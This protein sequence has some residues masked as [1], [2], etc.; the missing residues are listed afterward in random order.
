[1]FPFQMFRQVF[2]FL[3]VL[4]APALAGMDGRDLSDLQAFYSFDGGNQTGQAGAPVPDDS[5]AGNSGTLYGA[6]YVPEGGGFSL[7]FDGRGAFAKCAHLKRMLFGGDPFSVD[8][9]IKLESLKPGV[10]LGKKGEGLDSAGWL[11]EVSESG[12]HL[13]VILADGSRHEVLEFPLPSPEEWHHVALVRDGE[14][15]AAYVDGEEVE[16]R[17]DPAMGMDVSNDGAFLHLGKTFGSIRSFHGRLDD[18]AVW[19]RA[20]T[21]EEIKRAVE[22]LQSEKKEQAGAPDKGD[23]R[24]GLVFHYRFDEDP[25]KVASDLS[26]NGHNGTIHDGQYLPAENDEPGALRFNG[27][28]TYVDIPAA[29]GLKI[30]GDMTLEMWVRENGP[31]QT[32]GSLLFGEVSPGA[33]YLFSIDSAYNLLFSLR[34]ESEYGY[35]RVSLPVTRRF[36]DSEWAHLAVVVEYP[37]CRFYRNGELVRDQF[38]PI[39][40]VKSQ[41]GRGVRL[42]GEP[43]NNYFSPIDLREFSLHRR[44]LTP[45][46]IAARAKGEE[47]AGLS[48]AELA[49]EPDWYS[50]HLKLRYTA[51]DVEKAGA[52]TQF[53]LLVDGKVV[54]SKEAGL[55][56]VSGSRSG[57]S[58]AEVSFP[59][60]DYAGKVV[61][62]RARGHEQLV[63]TTAALE[64]PAWIQ[65]RIGEYDGV[66]KP[67]TPI[68]VSRLSDRNVEV[69]VWGR[70]YVFDGSLFPSQ[71]FA[72]NEGLLAGSSHLLA[73]VG[74]RKTD[75]SPGPI[76]V[77]KASADVVKLSQ[78]WTG[79]NLKLLVEATL[80]YDGFLRYRCVLGST[81]PV[82]IQQLTLTLPLRA[83]RALFCYADRAYPLVEGNYVGTFQSGAIQKPLG[84]QFS[85]SVWIGDDD[86]GLTWQAESD[87]HW[88]PADP[89]KTLEVLPEGK[90]VRFKANFL[91]TS[92]TLRPG[93]DKVYEF[94]LL[95]TP[96]KPLARDAWDLRIARYEPWGTDFGL[97]DRKVNGRP[98]LEVIHESGVRRLF[99]FVTDAYSWPMPVHEKFSDGLSRMVKAVHDGNL[100]VHP[101][102]IHQR[103]AVEVPEFDLYGA[104]MANRPMKSYSQP[105]TFPRN[106]A[107][108]G[109][110]NTDF[111]AD[112]SSTVFMCTKSEALQDA[113]IGSLDRRLEKYGEDGVY[114]DGTVHVG[115]LCFNE[116]HGCGYRDEDGKLH[117]TYPTFSIREFM[118]RISNTVK[119][120]NPEGIVDAHSSYGYNPSAL[121]YADVMWTGEQ[122]H[123]L[124]KTGT[125]YV[126][127]ELTTDK[128]RT[129]FTGRQLGIAAETLHYRLRNPMKIAATS[130]LHDISPRYS[131]NAFDNSTQSADSYFKL[132]PKLWKMRDEFGANEAEKLFYW[133]NEEYVAVANTGAYATLFKHPRNGTLA[134]VSN[135][136]REAQDV[137]VHFDLGK[138]GLSE[139]TLRVFDPLTGQD[140]DLTTD[141]RLKLPLGSESWKYVWLK[142]SNEMAP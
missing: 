19:R 31:P 35:E 82:D 101:Y 131:T 120:H 134:L 90:E 37:R 126:A 93:Q 115:P 81:H 4:T 1:M 33:N 45:E 129:E 141:G 32:K 38:M 110:V 61:E 87:Q 55:R 51:K 117:G 50:G 47:F 114:L 78:D 99:S 124:R 94:A 5:V 102:V 72:A 52:K 53:E 142:P 119:A 17:S 132:V 85:P 65:S 80:E 26:G 91:T 30:D 137:D 127:E 69:S 108:P 88:K 18:V 49:I 70:K 22:A 7:L 68:E 3:A 64:K 109:S 36:L 112:S 116:E 86:R 77:D 56:N 66:P 24:R 118:R 75:W 28:S 48:A 92:T 67:W 135:L 96:V 2:L 98:E 84:F 42:G 128:F 8:F 83:E 60:S 16:R 23:A 29:E 105:M 107:R 121:A 139:T 103:V 63:E 62:A 34:T 74:D 11:V 9:W 39:F 76:K 14:S 6:Q 97:P 73:E 21:P 44:A 40:G 12:D 46:E 106:P 100:K 136:S 25:G 95:A 130:L 89:Q 13:R 20:L 41:A 133:R 111:G 79:G 15:L 125:E 58:S 122:W 10:V 138:L 59:L 27:S 57:R 71:I 104:D 43:A 54:E 123:H 140:L 113:F